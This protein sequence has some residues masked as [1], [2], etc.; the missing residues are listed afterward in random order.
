MYGSEKNSFIS[1]ERDPTVCVLILYAYFKFTIRNIPCAVS[2]DYAYDW[3][4][5]ARIRVCVC[6]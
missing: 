5:C 6:V 1:R 3:Y 2:R 4:P